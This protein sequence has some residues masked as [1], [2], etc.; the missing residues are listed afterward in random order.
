[1]KTKTKILAASVAAV[2]ITGGIGATMATAETPTPAPTAPSSATPTQKADKAKNGA[3]HQGKS[4]ERR[5]LH[6][7][8]TLGGKKARVVD[9]QRGTVA[10]VSGTSITV[11]SKD[12]F[13]ASYVV[14]SATKIR[15]AK[16]ATTISNVGLN[17]KVR[18]RATKVGGTV[19]AKVI[20][21]QAK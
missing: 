11:K 3:K 21:E 8:V 2:A 1:V 17:D 12:G 20:V 5:A 9:F 13:T 19:T 4:L 15:Q 7:E 10:K 16:K 18:I 6:G 14:G